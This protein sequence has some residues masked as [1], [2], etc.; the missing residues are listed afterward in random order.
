MALSKE[1]RL[2]I[3]EMI[4]KETDRCFPDADEKTRRRIKK[5]LRGAESDVIELTDPHAADIHRRIDP[6]F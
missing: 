6:E 2:E 5:A 3:R 1:V 4:L